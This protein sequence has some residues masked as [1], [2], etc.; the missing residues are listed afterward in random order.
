MR[1]RFCSW[2]PEREGLRWGSRS[3]VPAR[4]AQLWEQLSDQR[5]AAGPSPRCTFSYGFQSVFPAVSCLR[6]SLPPSLSL[7]HGFSTIQN[8]EL[9]VLLLTAAGEGWMLCCEPQVVN[10]GSQG[11][12]VLLKC[13]FLQGKGWPGPSLSNG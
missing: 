1:E 9:N 7:L 12:L 10:L 2:K 5:A 3:S 13:D 8:Q 11:W 6:P 4:S